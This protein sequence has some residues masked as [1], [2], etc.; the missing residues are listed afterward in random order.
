MP[1]AAKSAVA[2]DTYV[3]DTRSH[4]FKINSDVNAEQFTADGSEANHYL[5]LEFACLGCHTDEDRAWASQDAEDVH[6][7]GFTGLPAVARR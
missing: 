2:L 3:G 4:I 1:F 6:G 5:T 7:A